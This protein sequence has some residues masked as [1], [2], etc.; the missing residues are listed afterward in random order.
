MPSFQGGTDCPSEVIHPLEVLR[1]KP[2]GLDYRAIALACSISEETVREY[3]LRAEEAGVV[4]PLPAGLG[5][6]PAPQRQAESRK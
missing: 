3:L 6:C 4:W 2:S 5:E 1:L